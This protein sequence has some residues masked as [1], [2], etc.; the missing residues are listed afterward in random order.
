[1]LFDNFEPCV[2]KIVGLTR[3]ENPTGEHFAWKGYKVLRVRNH[4]PW[5]LTHPARLKKMTSSSNPHPEN[6]GNSATQVWRQPVAS[7]SCQPIPHSV[8]LFRP[9]CWCSSTCCTKRKKFDPRLP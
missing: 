6:L 1:M 7:P 8:P 4:Q 9:T 5:L 2:P 3:A